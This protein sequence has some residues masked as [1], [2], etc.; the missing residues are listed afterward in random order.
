MESSDLC[1]AA[2]GC[3]AQLVGSLGFLGSYRDGLPS[4]GPSSSLY[5]PASRLLSL[6]LS[7]ISS[8]VSL[9][10]FPAFIATTMQLYDTL[11]GLQGLPLLVLQSEVSFSILAP[12]APP[13]SAP[14]LIPAPGCER[15]GKRGSLCPQGHFLHKAPSLLNSQSPRE[16][17]FCVL[18]R[19]CGCSQQRSEAVLGSLHLGQHQNSLLN[20]VVNCCVRQ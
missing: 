17:A 14:E 16:L 5:F 20:D 4:P 6:G 11:F 18:C 8:W 3:P 1:C 12:A 10:V 7:S 9:R 15:K 13:C 19:G 2:L